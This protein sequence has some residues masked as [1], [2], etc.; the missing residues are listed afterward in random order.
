MPAT[1]NWNVTWL[2]HNA[3]RSYPLANDATKQD[4][5]DTF[6]L[7]D[8]LI[9]GLYLAVPLAQI[10]DPAAFFLKTLLVLPSSIKIEIGYYNGSSNITVATAAVLR[11]AHTFG[12]SYSLRG[13]GDF[14]DAGGHVVLGHFANL[15]LQ[16]AGSWQF[17]LA[18]G[19]LE[20]DVVRPQLRGIT[21]IRVANGTSVGEPLTGDIIL[22][23][24]RNF[25]IV[26]L[27]VVGEDPVLQ[28]DAIEGEG[29]NEECVCEDGTPTSEP[30]R[31]ISKIKPTADGNFTLEGSDCVE[32][33][34]ITNG[35]QIRNTC[36]E[37]CCGCKELRVVTE[38]LEQFGR[39]A[40]T[41]QNFLV[42]LEAQ[43]TQMN[44]SVLGSR[45]NDR[46]CL[47]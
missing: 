5:S 7:P 38:S 27:L 37:P 10:V 36:S 13:V 33:T 20:P 26:P 45:L 34:A 30:I 44:S 42:S 6:K 18:D 14:Y 8:D 43:V 40:T 23:P 11:S 39:Q 32:L 31:T 46:T 25:R 9:V 47:T 22:R 41:L 3:G 12:D 35:L 19:R 1:R 21:S 17:E 16:P 2:N 29:L 15:D 24:G 4:V 28:F